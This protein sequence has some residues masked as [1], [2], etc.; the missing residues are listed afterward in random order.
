V[1]VN[2]GESLRL[3]RKALRYAETDPE[4]FLGTA[5]R[6]AESILLDIAMQEAVGSKPT[7]ESLLTVLV[8]KGLVPPKV[9][10]AIRTIQNYGNVRRQPWDGHQVAVGREAHRLQLTGRIGLGHAD[11]TAGTQFPLTHG[12]VPQ[13]GRQQVTAVR[14]RAHRFHRAA[15]SHEDTDAPVRD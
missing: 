1:T 7:L 4:V 15:V 2:E 8:A 13:T 10:L 3:Y 5:R 11:T 14:G 9:V 12:T 6:A